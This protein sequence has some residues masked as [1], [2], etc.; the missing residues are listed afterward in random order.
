MIPSRRF[1]VSKFPAFIPSLS[2]VRRTGAGIGRL[3]PR[4]VE[5]VHRTD[6]VVGHR[7]E[8]FDG[9]L[10]LAEFAPQIVHGGLELGAQLMSPVRKEEVTHGGAFPPADN[11]ARRYPSEL[12][13]PPLL[14]LAPPDPPS[15]TGATMPETPIPNPKPP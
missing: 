5:L 12:V 3:R 8:L 13:P 14:P 9:S 7:P 15:K 4:R 6:A 2:S 11:C 1:V 10:E